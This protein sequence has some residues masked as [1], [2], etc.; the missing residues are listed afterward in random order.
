MSGWLLRLDFLKLTFWNGSW[1]FVWRITSGLGEQSLSGFVTRCIGEVHMTI[2]SSSQSVMDESQG[3]EA[4]ARDAQ[5]RDGR[6]GE[7]G[8][9][10]FSRRSRCDVSR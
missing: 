8:A 4:V 3:F 2:S 5:F 6:T 10:I 1:H 9:G 7:G